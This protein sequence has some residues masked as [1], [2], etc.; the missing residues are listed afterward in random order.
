MT[1]TRNPVAKSYKKDMFFRGGHGGTQYTKTG[2]YS[3]IR[4]RGGGPGGTK[5]IQVSIFKFLE[6]GK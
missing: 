2:A 1:W 5:Q 4:L 3:K 6:R